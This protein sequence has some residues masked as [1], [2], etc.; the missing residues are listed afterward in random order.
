MAV[1]SD[2]RNID[3]MPCAEL[4]DPKTLNVRSRSIDVRGDFYNLLRLP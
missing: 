3:G 4:I 1:V 2:S